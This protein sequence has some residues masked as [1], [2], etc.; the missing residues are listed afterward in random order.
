MIERNLALK[1]GLKNGKRILSWQAFTPCKRLNDGSGQE[2][3]N[4]RPVRSDS[5]CS[6]GPFFSTLQ[7]FNISTKFRLLVHYRFLEKLLYFGGTGLFYRFD[8]AKP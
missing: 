8:Q 1:F 2:T 3:E 7:P 5:K 4:Q 6:I